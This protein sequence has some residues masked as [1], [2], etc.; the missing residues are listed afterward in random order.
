MYIWASGI[1]QKSDHSQKKYPT[2]KELKCLAIFSLMDIEKSKINFVENSAKK[3][4]SI[5][6]QR[7]VNFFIFCQ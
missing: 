6:L 5:K 7:L 1:Y 3:Q 2:G 4:Q